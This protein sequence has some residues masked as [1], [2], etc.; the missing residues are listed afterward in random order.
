[1]HGAIDISHRATWSQ[2][3]VAWRYNRGAERWGAN[4]DSVGAEVIMDEQTARCCLDIHDV[5]T[6]TCLQMGKVAG[7]GD[8]KRVA[9]AT[10]GD[11]K[12]L[13]SIK[14]DRGGR[15]AGHGR[16]GDEY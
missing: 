7:V 3:R 15:N 2:W 11:S 13:D 4:P 9:A 14:R 1:M 6:V 5:I 16:I 8:G 12:T 10:P